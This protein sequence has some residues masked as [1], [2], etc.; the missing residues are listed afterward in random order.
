MGNRRT[1]ITL[2]SVALLGVCLVAAT[3][4][5]SSTSEPARKVSL[6]LGNGLSMEMFLIPAGKFL[7]GS[8]EGEKGRSTNEG[9]LH[10]VTISRAFYMGVF[11]VTQEQYE[12]VM[13][14]DPSHFKGAK[15][16]VETVSWHDAVDFCKKLAEKTGKK[17]RLP[18]EAEWEYACRAGSKTRFCFGDDETDLR[19][20]TWYTA[21]SDSKTHP[22]GEKTPNA[23]GLYDMHGNVWEWCSDCW[24]V[25]Y[26]NAK[27]EDPQGPAS[28][29]FRV[30]RGGGWNVNPTYCRS[31]L[32][33]R[34]SPDDR[35]LNLGF[36]VAVD[37]R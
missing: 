9:P 12:A 35:Y 14:K 31:A 16:P 13:G 28:G 11:E 7:M 18:T 36:R 20:H 24:A 37:S 10:E 4:P 3:R 32:R 8:P 15:N 21:N 27:N 25:S 5:A 2:L 1:G 29:A 23:W 26:A 17:V 19:D 33:F 34:S 6:D 22:A 30:L